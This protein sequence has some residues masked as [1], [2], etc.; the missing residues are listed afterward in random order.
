M[1]VPP[2]LVP[3]QAGPRAL[4]RYLSRPTAFNYSLSWSVPQEEKADEEG[5]HLDGE[6]LVKD[7]VTYKPGDFLFLSPGTLDALED[8]AAAALPVAEYAAKGRFHKGGANAGL[9][10]YGIAQLLRVLPPADGK[11]KAKKVGA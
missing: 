5:W 9:R 6:A 2:G 7:G 1:L 4:P 11:K 3:G 10:A 8:A